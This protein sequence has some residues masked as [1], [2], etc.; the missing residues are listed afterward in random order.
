MATS[1]PKRTR[2]NNRVDRHGSQ[3]TKIWTSL[4]FD[5]NAESHRKEA[6]EAAAAVT[7]HHNLINST[8]SSG[9]RT[10][11]KSE[12]KAMVSRKRVSAAAF[13][14]PSCKS[15]VKRKGDEP[16]GCQQSVK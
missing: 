1:K 7:E 12:G 16:D 11:R 13:I 2:I 6:A 9:R 15:L 14:C 3:T 10:Y 5:T 8:V 4:F